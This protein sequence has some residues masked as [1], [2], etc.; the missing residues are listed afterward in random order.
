MMVLSGCVSQLDADLDAST[1]R[2]SAEAP[3][4]PS[5]TTCNLE[6]GTCEIGEIPQRPPILAAQLSEVT[7]F[8]RYLVEV[9]L[10]LTVSD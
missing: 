7:G 10:D 8:G 2:C 4:C 6:S 5:G 1:I 9:P 3:G